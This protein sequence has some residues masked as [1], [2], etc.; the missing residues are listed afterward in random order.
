MNVAFY[1][2]I[3]GFF[4]T[5]SHA[6]AITKKQIVGTWQL[7]SYTIMNGENA[8]PWC[9]EPFGIISYFSNGYMAV[10]INCKDADQKLVP[11]PKDMVFYTGKYT[12]KG[13]TI[14]HHV[15]NSSELSRIDQTLE[16]NAHIEG[17]KITLTGKGTKGLV[18][19]VW[20]K[21]Q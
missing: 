15:Q 11:D 20:K 7:Q 17:D 19:L 21:L 10:G 12:L 4:S 14:L 18:R 16:R 2:I 6:A 8:E 13:N 1:L 3:I 5:V 9:H